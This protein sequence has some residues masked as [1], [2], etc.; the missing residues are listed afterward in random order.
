MSLNL[1]V[2]NVLLNCRRCSRWFFA[3]FLFFACQPSHA[4]PMIP[5]TYSGSLSYGYGYSKA[6]ESESESATLSATVAGNGFIW[7]PWF[8]ILGVG[9]SLGVSESGTN[10]SGS[11]STSTVGSGNLRLTVFPQS[12]FPFVFS[13]SRT[14]SRLESSGSSFGKSDHFFSTRAFM[15]QTYYG[16]T[17]YVA[18][19]SWDHGEFES[20][21]SKSKNDSLNASVKG[22]QAKHSYSASGGYTQSERSNSPLEPSTTRLE[23]QHNYIPSAEMGISSTTSYTRNDTGQSGSISIFEIVQ[24]SSVFG[25]R[26][27][28]RPYTISGGARVSAS[29]SGTGSESKSMSTNIGASYNITR[30]LRALA[31]GLISVSESQ[32]TNTVSTSENLTLNYFSQQYFV[33]GFSWNWNSNAG[34]ANSNNKVD[35]QSSSQ[36]S[37]SMGLSHSFNKN[38][39]VGRT[40]SANI[41]FTQSGSVNKS[42]ELDK[43]TYGVAH[44]LGLGWSRRGASS[45]TFANLSVTDTRTSGENSTT[46]QMLTAQLTQRSALSRVSSLSAN[47][48]FQASRQDLP[49]EDDGSDPKT[50]SASASY[51]N[52][53]AFGIYPL[54]FNTRLAYNKR[55]TGG[56]SD[57]ETTESDSRLDYRVGLLTTSLSFRIMQ[58]EGGTLSETINFTLTRTF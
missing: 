15:S 54:R 58:V 3:A 17:G 31:T 44:G 9:V 2:K 35:E 18:R 4:L 14:D 50:L 39:A 26:P 23:L 24:A 16:R 19:F 57:S 40:A 33:G 43:E 41:A 7:Q 27:I 22:R 38:W 20:D 47:V 45:G 6:A 55:L 12:R 42:S 49:G 56:S 10:T 8:I 52:G 13:L 1:T 30:S 21:R 28:D 48:V 53:R 25:W 46:N 32:G 29:D 11:S 36:Q 5:M 51:A 37:A 34:I